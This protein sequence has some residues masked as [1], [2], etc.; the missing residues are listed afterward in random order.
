MQGPQRR[1]L[2]RIGLSAVLRVAKS[3]PSRTIRMRPRELTR[4]VTLINTQAGA[5]ADDT[6]WEA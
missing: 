4:V 6:I 3:A 2:P 1:P 5:S